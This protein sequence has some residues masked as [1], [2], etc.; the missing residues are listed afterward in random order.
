M[1]NGK[2]GKASLHA[3]IFSR[4]FANK[5]WAHTL[6]TMTT[7]NMN[8][9][10]FDEA[11]PLISIFIYNYDLAELTNCLDH[12]IGCRQLMNFEVI[13]CD[14]CT[15]DGSWKVANDFMRQYPDLITITRSQAPF[16]PAW[17]EGKIK[18]QM[19]RGKYFVALTR[20]RR[21]DPKYVG[22][23]ISRLESDPM[24]VHSYIGKTREFISPRIYDRP[25]P[26]VKGSENPLVSI[27]VY[28]YE[29]GRYLSQCLE[30]VAAQTYK[31]IEIC[32]SDNASTD[33]S[34][35][36]ALKFF[37]H[38]PKRMS[39]T[40]NRSNFGY[41][42]NQENTHYDAQGKYMLFLCSDDAIRPNFVER[43]VTL[44]E[45]FSDAAYAMV[46]RDIIDEDNKLSS[47]PPF[48]NQTCVVPGEEQTA[49]YMM[50]TVNPSISQVLYL[51][52]KFTE[53]SK[54]D[55]LNSRWFGARILDFNLCCENSMVY[56]NEPLLLN[57]VHSL[58]E[59]T[60]ISDNLLQCIGHY[61]L[62][63]QFADVATTIG[64]S[65]T[66]GR[67]DDAVEKSGKLCLRYCVRFL[68]QNNEAIALRY[69]RLAEA[70][71]P[72]V[73]SDTMFNKL[74]D[75]WNS[76]DEKLKLEIVTDINNQLNFSARTVS[77]APPPG[78]IPC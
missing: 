69:F 19:V 15:E 13:L 77:Y 60:F 31:N 28:N 14:D 41:S 7:D 22:E 54:I 29:Y 71:F 36:I 4:F 27:C 75:Y 32:F 57:R 49:V 44:L 74:T 40:R 9:S 61:S 63:H 1:K 39:L 73:T 20:G 58:S 52:E 17:H 48:Y 34:W 2:I 23:I 51:R 56:I 11:R 25:S 47:E 64:F 30:S 38:Y 33:D 10:I 55:S 12:I 26:E 5:Q 53:K 78:S 35:E 70:L 8:T 45:K 46:H 37:E 76:S 65:K 42:C 18:L 67:L 6:Q 68:M 43:C 59:G 72:G 66:A 24:L 3:N 62:A 16:G 50:A 21:F